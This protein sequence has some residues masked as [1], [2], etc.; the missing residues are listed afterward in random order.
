[1]KK[2]I[3]L[4]FTPINKKYK[5]ALTHYAPP[6]GLVA[7]ANYI[8]ERLQNVR[9]SILD[10]SV[11]HSMEDIIKFIEDEKPDIVAQSVQLISYENS[12][13]IAKS[14]HNIGS[15]NVLG[16]QHATQM[17]DA[18]IFRQQGLID[19]VSIEDG[20][21]SLLGLLEER[22]ISEIPNL[23]FMKDGKI[24]RTKYFQ[25]DLKNAP[26]LD[27]SIV[28]FKPYQK[29][30]NESN[31]TNPNPINNYLRVYSHKG[32]GN[33][34]N[35]VGCVFCG[36]ADKG[37]RFKSPEKFWEDIKIC[38]DEFKAD[39]IFDV[40]DDFLYNH[41]W[42]SKV[43]EIKPD[44]RKKF[45][46]GIFARA[47]RVNLSIAK[48][49][50]K[51]GVTD[52]VIGFESGDEEV[53]RRCNKRDTSTETSLIAA[54]ALATAGID[55]TASFVL[56]LPGENSESLKK[57][58]KCAEKVVNIITEKLGRPPREMVGNLIEP[59]PGSIAYNQLL[60]AYPGK[61][62][63]NDYVPLDEM[64]RD[65]FKYYFGLDSLKSYLEFRKELNK[66]AQEIHGLVSF[67]DSQG[68]LEDEFV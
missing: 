7:L 61:Y 39:Y 4:I 49:L 21:E 53:L 12:L 22:D 60:K 68:W 6:L 17:A 50:K 42:V 15:I 66:A 47:N 65:Y 2:H 20:E 32:C 26:K 44:I 27:Y 24:N 59:S 38:A 55:I 1:M 9:I 11:T 31:F 51:I 58:I 37:V 13:V 14:A 25:L 34:K 57:T 23:V 19:Y 3:A 16:G 36:R 10:G 41:D 45:E 62:Y 56:G 67:S 52:V 30:L 5:D 40:G 48:K 43:A 28:D 64:Q 46:L 33:R 54:D 18:I 63:L 8:S 35:S 29:L